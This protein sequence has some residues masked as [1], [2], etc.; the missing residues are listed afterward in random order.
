MAEKLFKALKRPM[1]RHNAKTQILTLTVGERLSK[2]LAT[3][4]LK[5]SGTLRKAHYLAADAP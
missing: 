5:Q 4:Y 1:Q 3:R 2:N